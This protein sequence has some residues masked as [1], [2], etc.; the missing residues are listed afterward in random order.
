MA[1]H[2]LMSKALGSPSAAGPASQATSGQMY[3]TEWLASTPVAYTNGIAANDASWELRLHTS[4]G[5]ACTLAAP[6]AA[7]D[8]LGRS[9]RA[10]TTSLAAVQTLL[11]LEG[12]GGLAVIGQGVQ[13]S[14]SAFSSS[15]LGGL[16]RVV[17]LE[18]PAG[19][20]EMLASDRPSTMPAAGSMELKSDGYG[21]MVRAA[22]TLAPRLQTGDSGLESTPSVPPEPSTYLITGGS[23]GIARLTGRWLAACQPPSGS[24][25]ISISRTPGLLTAAPS[26]LSMMGKDSLITELQGDVSA[27]EDCMDTSAFLRQV[28]HRTVLDCV[29]LC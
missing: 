7:A 26:L 6:P 24:H 21:A 1:M 17:S 5:L 13:D 16:L 19:R 2:S 23:G 4:T 28:G 25:V 10:F 29:G 12:P 11:R 20:W 27:M 3:C 18:E 8:I 15:A 14:L 22:T 9:A